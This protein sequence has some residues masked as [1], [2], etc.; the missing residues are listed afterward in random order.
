MDAAQPR[1][2]RHVILIIVLAGVFMSVLDGV[3]VNIALPN[4][5]GFFHVNV[6]ESQWVVTSYLLAQTS[7]LII[8]GRIAERTGKAVMLTAGL[9]TFTLFSFL[10]GLA[11]TMELLVLFRLLQGVG[12]SMLFS[13]SAAIIFQVF[14]HEERGKA[15]GYLGSIVAL[16]AMAGPVIGGFLVGSFGWQSIFLLNVPI[17]MVAMVAAL[18]ML[19]LEERCIECLRMDYPGAVLWSTVVVSFLLLLGLLGDTGSL[20]LAGAALLI[21]LAASLALFIRRERR[22]TYPL[23]DISVFRVP[24]FT[25]TGL[26]MVTFFISMSMVTILGPFYYEGVLDFSPEQVGL[27]F[28]VLPAVMMFGSPL[29][30]RWYDRTHSQLLAVV[31]MVV[32][33][34]SLV[35]LAYGFVERDVAMTIVAFLVMGVSSSLFQSPNNT[36]LMTA[37]PRE[38]S[39]T[40][41]SVQATLRNISMAAGV[42][43]STI[44]MTV[45]MG[46]MDYSAIAGGPLAGDLATAISIAVVISAVIS[47]VGA[48]LSYLGGRAKASE[49]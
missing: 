11:P 17:G 37:L 30:G 4:I 19:K 33:A 6:S 21:L 29:A 13:I 23:L 2:D 36:E 8:S 16:A 35:M 43:L 20:T 48:V 18:R 28:M 40:A 42:S 27:I 45:L 25:L 12:A 14:G 1:R 38:K 34:V 31:G 39:G 15:M 32:R 5:T 44:I 7:F 46:P 49:V 3:V 9:G 22:A 47:L 10:C 41:S 26:S 24:R